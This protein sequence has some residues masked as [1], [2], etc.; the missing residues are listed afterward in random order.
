MFRI[1]GGKRLMEAVAVVCCWLLIV[2]HL[3][4]VDIEEGSREGLLYCIV[5]HLLIN[6]AVH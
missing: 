2:G 3:L 5:V 4:F 1:S 6:K